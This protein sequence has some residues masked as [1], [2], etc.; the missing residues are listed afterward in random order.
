MGDLPAFVRMLQFDAESTQALEAA[1]LRDG[2][3]Q[4]A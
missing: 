4:E 2:H 3:R 1:R